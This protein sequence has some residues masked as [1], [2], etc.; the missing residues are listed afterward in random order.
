M[1]YVGTGRQGKYMHELMTF[2]IWNL[3]FRLR[4]DILSAATPEGNPI[5]ILINVHAQF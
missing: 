4:Q 5:I 3:Y 1:K 2:K